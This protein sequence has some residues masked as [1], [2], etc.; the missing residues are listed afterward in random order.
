M[1]ILRDRAGELM[2][3][4]DTDEA[5]HAASA[6]VEKSQHGLSTDEDS[7]V[8]FATSLEVRGDI[9]RQ[10][11]NL[12][13]ARDDYRQAIMV[14]EE[15]EDHDAQLGRLYAGLGAV[16]DLMGRREETENAWTRAVEHFE[17]MDPPG[18]LDV[19]AMC[20]NLAFLRRSAGDYDAAETYFLKAL[21][22]SHRE[23][24]PQ[25]EETALLCNNLGACYQA[26]GFFEQAREMHMMALETRVAEFGEGH[27]DTAQSHNNLALA[28]VMTGDAGAAGEHF[29]MAVDGFS[30]AGDG[31][32]DELQAV[33]GNYS[34]FLRQNGES[35]KAAEIEAQLAG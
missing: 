21:E 25:H 5:I 4:G 31:Y 29:Q 30:S 23:L 18:L 2:S 28:L 7:V 11:G 22:I 14:L 16:Y 32:A 9:Y 3:K 17:A 26:A 33:M 15:R 27:P 12:E 34:E 6:A 13:E 10:I 20:N 35:A 8:A 1:R 24:G 19:A